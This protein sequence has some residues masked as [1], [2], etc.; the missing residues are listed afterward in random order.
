MSS[1]V[2]RYNMAPNIEDLKAYPTYPVGT[3][4][5]A[6]GDDEKKE[7]LARQSKQRDYFT[8]V[9][10]PLLRLTHV[11]LIQYGQID[12]RKQGAARFPLFAARSKSWSADKPLAVVTGGVH[13]YETS[14]ILGALQFATNHIDEF[15]DNVNVL[16]LPCLSPWGFEAIN[17]WTPLAVDPNR[18]FKPEDPG[19]EEAGNAMRCIAEAAKESSSFL[20]HID[21]HETTNSDNLEFCPVRFARDGLVAADQPYDPIPD[22]FY[23]VANTH[24]DDPAFQKTMIDAVREVTHIAP[25][26]ERG[27]IIGEK[28]TGEGIITIEGRK[29]GLCGAHTDAT[30]ST[31]TEVYPDSPKATDEMCN[32]AQVACVRA[33]FKYAIAQT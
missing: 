11:D 25:A 32:E 2:L 5:Q 19:C 6:W 33:G 30:F 23:L 29:Y 8:M 16:V 15:S 10:S 24:N 26:D 31:T 1:L 3:Q 13:G 9:V 27:T 14:G 28:V 7:W 22:G 12:Y 4:G 18:Q 20:V 17:R 21:L